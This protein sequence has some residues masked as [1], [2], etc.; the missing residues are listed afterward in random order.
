MRLHAFFVA[1]R[2]LAVTLVAAALLATGCQRREAAP[3]QP[4]APPAAA[5]PTPQEPVAAASAPANGATVEVAPSAEPEPPRN[6]NLS[7]GRSAGL[8]DTADRLRLSAG[9]ALVV[10]RQTGAELY[11]KNEDAVLPIASLTKLMTALLLTEAKTDWDETIRIVDEDVDRMRNSRS[12]LRVGTELT[13]REA[14]HLA[15]MSSENRAAHALARTA[16]GGMDKFV[17]AM[18]A[19][20]KALGMKHTS[21]VDPTGLSNRNQSTVRDLAI[22]AAAAQQQDMIREFST[23]PRYQAQFGKRTVLYNNSNRLVK[24]PKWDIAL[25][26]T[27]Y[28][29]E[30]GHC[31]AMATRLE[32]RDVYVVLLDAGD[33]KGRYADAERLKRHVASLKELPDANL[34]AA[35]E[36]TKS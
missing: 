33:K 16:P 5:A 2:G 15:L 4:A 1:G 12:R 34:A 8:H 20:A 26:K 3:E 28:I 30:A 10:D 29:V 25:Q 7:F 17:A 32:G 13:R 23:T 9:A 22:L 36:S 31:V 24:S 6:P 14:L 35:K 11:G 21:F 18:N 19:K 27:G